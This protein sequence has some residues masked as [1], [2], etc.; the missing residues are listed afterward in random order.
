MRTVWWLE[1]A[2]A[3]PSP[4]CRMRPISPALAAHS[5]ACMRPS[6]P[7]STRLPSLR[8][9]QAPEYPHHH[10]VSGVGHALVGHALM[11][12]MMLFGASR[13]VRH[14]FLH[15]WERQLPPY[16]TRTSVVLVACRPQMTLPRRRHY[17]N[18]RNSYNVLFSSRSFLT[19]GGNA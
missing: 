13:C 19:G 16:R 8:W 3:R 4:Y 15:A 2:R 17:E 6:T 9:A 12:M 14:V 5:G 11:M 10:Q 1:E 7:E 18:Y